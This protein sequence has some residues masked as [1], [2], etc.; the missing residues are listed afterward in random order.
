MSDTSA[1]NKRIAK[2][3]IALYFR[4]IITMIVGLFTS[5]VILDSLGVQDYGIYNL[6]GGFVTM[7]N[8]F[9]A[10]LISATQRFI[11][12]D[13]GKGDMNG[14]RSTFSTSMIIFIMLSFII[15]MIA[16]AG[17]IWFIENKLTIPAERMTAA[18][19]VF[20]FSLVTLILNLVSFPYNA[21]IIAHER[22]KAFAYISIFDVV[23]KLLLTYLVYISPIDKLIF[24]SFLMCLIQLINRMIYNIYCRKNFE[25]SN[26]I[27]SV[28]WS[29]VKRIYAFTGW[30]L[31][32][33]VAVIGYTQGLNMLLGMFFT[34]VVNAARG[35]AVQV[36]SMIT[37]FVSN[38]QTALNPQIT[39]SYAS[40]DKEYM[41]KLIFVSSRV[42]YLLLFFFA[43]PLMLEANELLN[44]WLVEVPEYTVIFFRLIIIITMIDAISNPI[45]T[46]VEATGNIRVYQIVVGSLLLLIL[47]VSYIVLKLGGAPYTVFLVHIAFS[48]LAFCARLIMASRATGL[49]KRNFICKVLFPVTITTIV[50]TLFPLAAH[51]L[52]D[53]SLMRLIA[54]SFVSAVCTILS[55]YS[56]GITE[57][58]RKMVNQ[59]ILLQ[60]KRK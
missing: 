18:H 37:G 43:L 49:H 31:F 58:E 2:N 30:E 52:M 57:N 20:Q 44:L 24:Y 11:T 9:R 21:L 34:P 32:G 29:K 45:I 35:V 56:I 14:L 60:I 51:L 25:E 7:F 50:A 38:F 5:R 15:V 8:V 36:Q 40:G 26:M 41:F 22:M 53:E 10:G 12:F 28:D 1:N 6:V 46:S 19:W 3:T 48:S 55:A 4:M 47:P 27:W 42:S 13:L 16:E 59:K 54:V 33:S 23:A 17:G 39:K